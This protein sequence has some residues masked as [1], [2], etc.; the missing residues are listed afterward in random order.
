MKLNGGRARGGGGEEEENNV[1][2]QQVV[3]GTARYMGQ[4]HGQ[5]SR[6]GG[7]SF[8]AEQDM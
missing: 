2:Q 7:N 5:K 6:G 8:G 1:T 3:I 4:K